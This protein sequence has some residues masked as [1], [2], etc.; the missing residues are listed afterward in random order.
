MTIKEI[1]ELAGVS[2]STVSKVINKKDEGIREETRRRVLEI[3][4]QY[5]YTPQGNVLAAQKSRSSMLGVVFDSDGGND[6]V[7]PALS[8]A[9]SRSNYNVVVTVGRTPEEEL[10]NF[11][12]LAAQKVDGILWYPVQG[13]GF[14]GASY[15]EKYGIPVVSMDFRSRVSADNISFDYYELGYEMTDMLIAK[16]HERIL[17]VL[18]IPGRRAILLNQ[19]YRQC[20]REHGL[21][22]DESFTCNWVDYDD[23]P[24]VNFADYTAAVCYDMFLARKVAEYAEQEQ[25]LSVPGDLSIVTVSN[26]DMWMSYESISTLGRFFRDIATFAVRKLISKIDGE[27]DRSVFSQRFEFNHE[28]SIGV[29]RNIRSKCLVTVAPVAEETV[30]R[31]HE[32]D[33]DGFSHTALSQENIV[34]GC[35]IRQLH[36][37]QLLNVSCYPLWRIGNDAAGRRIYSYLKKENF[38]VEYVSLDNMLHTP[39]IFTI[40]RGDAVERIFSGNYEACLEGE[41]Y[42][43]RR[44]AIKRSHF[45]LMQGRQD[46][47][48]L[49]PFM[50]LAHRYS[51]KTVLKLNNAAELDALEPG[52]ADIIV[53]P[54]HGAEPV[55]DRLLDTL[56]RKHAQITAIIG[57]A[58][59]RW[60]GFGSSGQASR[61]SPLADVDMAAE[62][63]SAALA[64]FLPTDFDRAE[65][66]CEA[67]EKAYEFLK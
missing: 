32:Q 24:N 3:V 46:M 50:R 12:I 9:A 60:Y 20:M 43:G 33:A 56:E 42:A 16:G 28:R 37:A 23:T 39:Q 62:E 22:V 65:I 17:C 54:A 6:A 8:R 53:F 29:P 15:T 5:H 26:G 30:L 38:N 44:D 64:C 31:L 47:S 1:A 14:D 21:P 7:L 45:C 34:G 51:V 66:V 13:S 57:E 41:E 59:C 58:S 36:A 4:E 11:Q 52:D 63:F 19:G 35:G 2:I 55:S 49:A 27:E 67:V 48:A 18:H 40:Y 61:E 10:R 25:E